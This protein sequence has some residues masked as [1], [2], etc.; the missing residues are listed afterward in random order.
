[1]RR[2]TAQYR[3]F[4]RQPDVATLMAVA[5]LSRMPIGMVGLSM[6]LC[7]RESLGSYGLAGSISG[8]YFLAMAVGAPIQGRLIDRK[9][10][11]VVLRVTGLVGPLALLAML[12]AS[13]YGLGFAAVAAAAVTA[14]LFATPITVLTRTLWR[15]RFTRDE[16]RRRAFAIDAVMIEVNFTAGPAIVAGV[17]AIAHPT[18]AFALSIAVVVGSFLLFMLSPAL[19]YFRPE[20]AA[21]RHMLGPLTEPHL[22]LVFGASF[23]LAMGIGQLGYPAYATFLALPA[24]GGLLLAT[25]S[26]GSAVG[27]A[28]FGGITLR[29]PIERQFAAS[30]AL[31]ALPLLLHAFVDGPAAFAGVALLAGAAIAPSVACQSVLVSRLAPSR[32]ATEAFTWSSTFIVSGL[33]AGMA[34][35]GWLAEKQGPK[36]PFVAGAAIVGV[37]ALLARALPPGA[38]GAPDAP[39]H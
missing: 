21:R 24:L 3:D 27:G 18:A 32:Y 2:F 35:G 26:F 30:L 23:G 14:G 31:M 1:M 10:P 12:V 34:L 11:R 4:F 7:M 37:M 8:F 5:V 36:A 20:A 9:G 22:L 38:E 25:N 29:A 28:V 19:K 33:G 16:D 6:L 17:V 13:R 39:A 15:T